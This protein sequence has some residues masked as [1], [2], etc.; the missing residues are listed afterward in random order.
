MVRLLILSVLLLA[1]GCSLAPG[2]A[3]AERAAVTAVDAAEEEIK[4]FTDKKAD[5]YLTLPCAISIGA[6]YRLTNSIQQQA[7]TMLCS[8]RNQG[9]ATPPLTP[10]Q[11]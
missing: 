6:Y 4:A 8:G 1:S 5:V 11:P 2:G 10:V 3:Q 9:D 7:L